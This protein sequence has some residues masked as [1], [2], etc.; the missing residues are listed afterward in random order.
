M[1]SGPV[2]GWGFYLSYHDGLALQHRAGVCW[3]PGWAALSP[4]KL[5]VETPLWIQAAREGRVQLSASMLASTIK[6]V[7]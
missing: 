5:D 7:N 4:V 2:T 3:R 6:Y 1:L